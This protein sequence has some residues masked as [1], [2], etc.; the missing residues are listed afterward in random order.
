MKKVKAFECLRL[1]LERIR[2]VRYGPF[3]GPHIDIENWNVLCKLNLNDV[4]FIEK[5]LKFGMPIY[6]ILYNM[7][8]YLVYVFRSSLSQ[9][10]N[11]R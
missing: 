4:G 1:D 6:N 10:A 3:Y 5:I 2:E 9:S 11:F 7:L 8:V